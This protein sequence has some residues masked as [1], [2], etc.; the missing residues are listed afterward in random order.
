MTIRNYL[1]CTVFI[2]L[3]IMPVVLY[4]GSY[5]VG[6]NGKVIFRNCQFSLGYWNDNFDYMGLLGK[7]MKSGPDDFITSS[8]RLN[9]SFETKERCWYADAHL[10][11]ITD[12]YL[13][14]RTD[15]LTLILSTMQDFLCGKAKLSLGMVS[16]GDF[17]G[18]IIQNSYHHFAGHQPVNLPYSFKPKFGPYLGIGYFYQGLKFHRINVKVL[19]LDGH[20]LN[21]GINDFKI[22]SIFKAGDFRLNKLIQINPS[23]L[24]C[25]SWY[26]HLNQEYSSIFESGLGYGGLASLKIGSKWGISLWA[27]QDQ[28]RDN[29]A[30]FGISFHYALKNLKISDFDAIMF[31]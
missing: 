6:Q 14:Y 5:E 17:G 9:S 29:Q 28:Y 3:G 22:G 24:V 12:K 15:L 2:I 27:I 23:F 10:N 21:V 30:Q 18:D 1:A 20:S 19:I 13:N 4:C 11:L 16:S 31:P 8:F 26:H 7:K 25:Y